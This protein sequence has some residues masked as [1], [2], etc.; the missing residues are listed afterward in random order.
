VFRGLFVTVGNFDQ[1][2]FGPGPA[3]EFHAHRDAELRM[4]AGC[5]MPKDYP[6]VPRISPNQHLSA[7]RQIIPLLVSTPFRNYCLRCGSFAKNGTPRACVT[8]AADTYMI[9]PAAT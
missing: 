8:E 9:C 1:D 3:Q 2:V 6:F 4:G 5:R 7:L